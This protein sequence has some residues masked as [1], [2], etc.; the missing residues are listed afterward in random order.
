[1]KI[2]IYIG[3]SQIEFE[4]RDYKEV[5]K[6]ASAFSQSTK[7]HLC[8]SQNVAL[9]YRYAVAKEGA[10]KGQGFDYYS[11]KCLDCFGRMQLGQYKT[12]GWFAKKWEKFEPYQGDQPVTHQEIKDELADFTPPPAPDEDTASHLSG[13][14]QDPF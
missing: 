4:G 9:D 5:S 8:K 6:E 1:M 7:C 10:N 3:K 14:D 11:V 13:D 12:G 2:K